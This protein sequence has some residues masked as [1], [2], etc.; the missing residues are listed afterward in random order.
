MDK[1]EQKEMNDLYKNHQ[2]KQIMDSIDGAVG[3][4]FRLRNSL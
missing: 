2:N 1:K 3:F 4:K